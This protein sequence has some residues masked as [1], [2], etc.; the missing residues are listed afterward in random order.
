MKLV[1]LSTAAAIAAGLAT[2]ASAVELTEAIKG[3]DVSGYIRYRM[4]DTELDGTNWTQ[5]NTVA[6]WASEDHK[7]KIRVHGKIPVNDDVTANVLVGAGEATLDDLTGDANAGLNIMHAFFTYTGVENLTVMAGKQGIPS[8]WNDDEI[9]SGLVAMYNAGPVTFAG[10]AFAN[11]NTG[12]NTL[13]VTGGTAAAGNDN[14]DDILAAAVI[15]SVEMV[16]FSAWYAAHE[17]MFKSYTVSADASFD[18]VNVGFRHTNLTLNDFVANVGPLNTALA[19]TREN[20]LT[21]IYASA[22]ID[23]FNVSAAYGKTGDQTGVVTSGLGLASG[24]AYDVDAATD[25]GFEQAYL[26]NLQDADAIVLGASATMDK[27]TVAVDYLNGEVNGAQN[28]A[29]ADDYDVTELMPSVK[30][31]MSDNFYVKA[32]YSMM[33]TEMQVTGTESSSDFTRLEVK[34]TF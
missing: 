20:E 23:M 28:D 11:T 25:F 18:M 4:E 10:A 30:Y 33:D 19:D 13:A 16:N 21:K 9:G 5:A 31:Q 15:G 6:N 3:V 12:Y 24:V 7:Y 17:N 32:L 27:V 22:D 34:Y 8:P 14:G 1:K 26:G 2:S 29:G